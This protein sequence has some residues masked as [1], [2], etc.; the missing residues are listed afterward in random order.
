MSNLYNEIIFSGKKLFYYQDITGYKM[1]L[2]EKRERLKLQRMA[3][4]VIDVQNEMFEESNPVY[5]AEY[6]IG[7]IQ[8]L[9]QKAGSAAIPVIFVQHND[10]ALVK[11]THYW[12]IHPSISPKEEDTI[13]QKWNPD[14]FQE[15]NL[16]EE[17]KT[18]GI[19]HLVVTGNQ[20]EMCVD[21]TCRRAF[22]LGYK[23]TL[24]EDAHGTWDSDSLS[25]EQIIEHHN[26]VLS[27]FIELKK[28]K[29]I[30]FSN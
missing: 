6:L 16:E 23:V 21:T 27:N 1:L 10:E 3:L 17:L 9:I 30:Q 14:S 22:S 4:L 25:A 28:T 24:V 18:K 7:N 2:F 8:S 11:G 20:T 19:Q 29:E 15:T 13:I 5:K 12:Q 26:R